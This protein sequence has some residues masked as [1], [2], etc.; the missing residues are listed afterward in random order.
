MSLSGRVR[1]LFLAELERH[2]LSAEEQED[3]TFVILLG[4]FT[5]TASLENIA[6]EF[7]QTGDESLVAHFVQTIRETTQLVPDTWEK[8]RSRLYLSVEP[9]DHDFGDVYHQHV[10]DQVALVLVY[11]S[12]PAQHIVWITPTMLQAWGVTR[13]R[14]EAHATDNLA[15]LLDATP[16]ETTEADGHKLGM[17]ATHSP[18]KASLI[19]A[20]NLRAKVESTLGWPILAV[21]PTRDF[22]YLIP[23]SAEALLEGVGRVVIGEY[24]KRGYPVSTEVFRID[25][26][27]PQ[28]TGAF[29]SPFNPPPGMKA[30]HHD[31]M[32]TFFLPRAWE[33]D[34]D[35]ND[36][37]IYFDPAEES[38]YLSVVTQ[39]FSSTNEIAPDQPHRCLETIARQ[40]DVEVE[41]WPGGRAAVH[42]Q[43][44]DDDMHVWTWAICGPIS[45]RRL[46]LAVFSHHEPIVRADSDEVQ[47]R[48]QML[49]SMLPRCLFHDRE[50]EEN[51][52]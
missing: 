18:L 22:C 24:T 5:V 2:Q 35:A 11:V 41:D 48:I 13:E 17:L 16:L 37:P 28:A 34:E 26:A 9:G 8:A 4:G 42:F 1:E 38:N 52:E 21:I 20:P 10:S 30:I 27:G 29:Q 14:A 43:G 36:E 46:G 47:A 15:R 33:E 40:E 31:E 25:D 23:T 39:Q 19:F 6:R 51:D 32:L 45:P 3:G 12:D 44:Q 49:R 7:E 50:A